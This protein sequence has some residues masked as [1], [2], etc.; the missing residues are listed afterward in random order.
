MSLKLGLGFQIR[1]QTGV[2]DA[3][4]CLKLGLGFQIGALN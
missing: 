4:E 2:T 3:D 1:F